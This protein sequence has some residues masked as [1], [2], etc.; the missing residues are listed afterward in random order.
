MGIFCS[1]NLA[2]NETVI[3]GNP[4]DD[5][6]VNYLT[7][8]WDSDTKNNRILNDLPNNEIVDEEALKKFKEMIELNFISLTILGNFSYQNELEN[9]VRLNK[10]ELDMNDIKIS[11]LALQDLNNHNQINNVLMNKINKVQ[12]V[13]KIKD[14]NK[15]HLNTKNYRFIQ[16]HSKCL[17][18]IDRLWCLNIIEKIKTLDKTIFK[19]NL[20]REMNVTVLETANNNTMSYENVVLI[21]IEKAFDSCDYEVVEKLLLKSL[22][23]KMEEEIATKL[24]KQYLYIVRQR[25]LYYK[26]NMI[27]YNKGIPTGF[28][29][30][31][32]IF[33]LIMDEMIHEW[34][35]TNKESFKLIDDFILNIF[36][37]DVYMKLV[38]NGLI[39]KDTIIKTLIE[40]FTKYKFK[41]N[42]NKCKAD[43]K[44]K[45]EG[46]SNIEESDF[47]LG[48]P[49]TRD[50]RKYCQIVLKQYN[51]TN[52]KQ[53][54]FVQIYLKII[55]KH[56][57]TRQIQGF[58]NYKLKPIMKTMDLLSFIEVYLI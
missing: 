20:V 49:F 11:Y 12:I 22:R 10:N 16:V 30:S 57:E 51:D 35:E 21:D 5:N 36:V 54:T 39:I 32:I 19:S 42:L 14:V 1:R 47:Y 58:F 13:P 18:L 2:K 6:F 27:N 37:D 53:D 56:E 50:I 23:R 26:D 33:S 25:I 52:K 3:I 38:N 15:D 55:N 29:S 34:L 8:L 48:I 31:N 7:T 41:V 28:S 4:T 44:L 46:F 24:T 9:E 43:E 40:T 45:I 17:K